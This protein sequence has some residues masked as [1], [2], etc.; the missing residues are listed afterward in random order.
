MDQPIQRKPDSGLESCYP[1]RRVI[2]FEFLFIA[3]MWRVIGGDGVDGSIRQCLNNCIHMLA[4]AKRWV[5]FCM[6]VITKN[7]LVRKRPMV[8]RNFT[9]NLQPLLFRPPHGFDRAFG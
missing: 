3:M 6:R 2:I 9:G 1:K 4:A 7:S 5:H 8:W